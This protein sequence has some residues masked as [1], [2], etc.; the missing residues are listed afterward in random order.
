M[1]GRGENGVLHVFEIEEL[2]WPTNF[3]RKLSRPAK[4]IF[5]E[6]GN[7]HQ[8]IEIGESKNNDLR[9]YTGGISVW[10]SRLVS[11]FTLVLRR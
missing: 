10:L 2:A 9:I 7:F 4:L 3:E 8:F 11:I 5:K 6:V 1:C